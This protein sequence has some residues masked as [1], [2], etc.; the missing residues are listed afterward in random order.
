M[1]ETSDL[2]AG[3]AA[4]ARRALASVGL[5][6]LE[7]LTAWGENELKNLHGI[8]PRAVEQLRRALQEHGLSLAADLTPDDQD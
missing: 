6:R 3:L 8:G 2:P 4:P 7:Q 5:S 1:K